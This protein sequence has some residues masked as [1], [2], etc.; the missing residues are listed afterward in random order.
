VIRDLRRYHRETNRFPASFHEINA[1][2]W[3]TKPQPDYGA[4]GR[5]ARAKN[6]YYR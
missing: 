4:K 5:E 2:L 3:Q 6:Y 1:R